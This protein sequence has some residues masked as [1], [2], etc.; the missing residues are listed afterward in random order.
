MSFFI[1]KNE[2]NLTHNTFAKTLFFKR[3]YS[4][5]LQTNVHNNLH[6]NV[7][8]VLPKHK[9]ISSDY[10]EIH[11]KIHPLDNL[12]IRYSPKTNSLYCKMS[13]QYNSQQTAYYR[14]LFAG[15]KYKFHNT[16]QRS[17]QNYLTAKKNNRSSNYS[18]D[19]QEYF[20][21]AEFVVTHL[22]SLH[23]HLPIG[24]HNQYTPSES[25]SISSTRI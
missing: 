10:R 21:S 17:Q 1:Q 12:N 4:T 5:K 18:T 23:T 14:T 9:R 19:I 22:Q 6:H 2:F 24:L 13:P 3:S 20:D 7:G 11:C 15:H 25:Q 16:P 8:E